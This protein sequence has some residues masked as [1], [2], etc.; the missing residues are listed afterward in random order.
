MVLFLVCRNVGWRD[1]ISAYFFSVKSVGTGRKAS[2]SC[3]VQRTRRFKIYAIGLMIRL[4]MVIYCRYNKELGG[5][6]I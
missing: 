3:L 6:W 5:Y 2:S 4:M 1:H